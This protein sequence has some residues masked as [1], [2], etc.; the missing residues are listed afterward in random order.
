MNDML[1]RAMMSAAAE[2]ESGERIYNFIRALGEHC[3]QMAD[4][5]QTGAQI[6]ERIRQ[7]FVY[8]TPTK[9]AAAAHVAAKMGLKQ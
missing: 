5:D 9:T 8:P 3:A 1:I 6:A 2:G 7:Q 4:C